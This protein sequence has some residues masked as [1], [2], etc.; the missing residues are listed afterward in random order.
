[1]N[2]QLDTEAFTPKNPNELKEAGND[3][4]DAPDYANETGLNMLV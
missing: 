2:F 1:M 3:Y 4:N